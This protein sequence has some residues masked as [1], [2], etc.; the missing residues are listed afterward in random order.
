MKTPSI[1]RFRE[2][3]LP[4]MLPEAARALP[5]T[6]RVVRPARNINWK[7]VSSFVVIAR[8]A[9]P[10][11]VERVRTALHGTSPGLPAGFYLSHTPTLRPF[12]HL[13]FHARH[14]EPS[15]QP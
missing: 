5:R 3:L 1:R 14:R 12:N 11:A 7:S 10:V 2:H 13:V 4:E 8:P 9:P 6:G 15:R